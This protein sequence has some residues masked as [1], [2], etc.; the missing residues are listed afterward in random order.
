MAVIVAARRRAGTV[1]RPAEAW[2]GINMGFLFRMGFWF[3]LVLLIL[4]FNF[5]QDD[6]QAKVSPIE[7]FFAARDAVSD[8]AGICERQPAVCETGQSALQTIGVRA[9]ESARIAYEL[10]DEHFGEKDKS[11]ATGSVAE[12]PRSAPTEAALEKPLPAEDV[13]MLPDHAP[14]PPR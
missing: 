3:A 8:I 10:L 4:P 12:K 11:M 1:A 6:G 2:K 14:L 7:T 13:M 9:R 5:G